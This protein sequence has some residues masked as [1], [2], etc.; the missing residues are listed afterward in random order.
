[1]KSNV[2]KV[3]LYQY[4]PAAKQHKTTSLIG[5][6]NWHLNINLVFATIA[7]NIYWIKYFHNQCI[8]MLNKYHYI[9]TKWIS[10]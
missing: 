9:K 5:Q 3:Y 8:I 4:L 10:W 2:L 7:K 6:G 1:M